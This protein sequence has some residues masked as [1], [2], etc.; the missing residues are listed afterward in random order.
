[1]GGARIARQQPGKLVPGEGIEPP[2]FGLQNRCSTTE[3]ARLIRG[4]LHSAKIFGA[5][6]C[7]ICGPDFRTGGAFTPTGIPASA[8]GGGGRRRAAGAGRPRR[9]RAARQGNPGKTEPR[10]LRTFASAI[11]SAPMEG[12][13]CSHDSRPSAQRRSVGAQPIS[14]LSFRALRGLR[15][16]N[17][18]AVAAVSWSS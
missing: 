14:C 15:R 2:T 6:F 7:R 4:L 16:A 11:C 18:A 1:M 8:A 5:K 3:L 17:P 13:T 9:R 12:P 10:C